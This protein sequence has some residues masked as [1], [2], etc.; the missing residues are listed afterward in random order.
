[1]LPVDRHYVPALAVR[2]A[3]VSRRESTGQVAGAIRV[4]RHAHASDGNRGR[5]R[6]GHAAA[7]STLVRG[8]AV[9]RDDS[10]LSSG[11]PQAA[12]AS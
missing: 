7:G 2:D 8:S 12:C 9:R 3:G 1:M 6:S 4:T 10:W 11:S 5:K